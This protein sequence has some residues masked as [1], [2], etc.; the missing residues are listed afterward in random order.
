MRLPRAWKRCFAIPRISLGPAKRSCRSLCGFTVSSRQNPSRSALRASRL[1]HSDAV[2]LH[3]M[4]A[5]NAGIRR[6]LGE[7][8]LATNLDIVFSPELMQFLAAR[9]LE[10]RR[11]YRI[12]RYDVSREIPSP[13]RVDDLL[14]FCQNHRL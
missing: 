4:I 8:V 3:Q 7:F 12:D 5:K 10:A 9:R 2:P 1:P 14:A 6:A 11:M 13:D